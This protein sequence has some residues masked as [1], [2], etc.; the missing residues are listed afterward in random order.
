MDEN[1]KCKNCHQAFRVSSADL[2]FYDKISPTFAQT[3]CLIP[4]PTLC[5]PCRNMRRMA[6]RNDRSFHSRKCDLTGKKIVALYTDQVPFPVF[7]HNEWYS[8]KWDAMSYGRDIDFSRPFFDQWHDLMT[9]VPRLSLDVVNCENSDYCNYCGDDKNCYLDIAGEANEDCYYNLFTKF[10]KNCVDCTFVYHSTLCYESIHCYH[11]YNVRS[12]MYLDTCSDCCFCFDLKG[13]KNCL[14]SM[15]LRNKEYYIFNKPHT[16]TEYE[17]KLKELKL[18]SYQAYQEHASA[19]QAKRIESGI[20]RDMYTISCEECS[21]NDIKNSKNC[22]AAFNVT[23]C[24]DCKYLYDVLNAKD[25]YDL[26]YSLYHPEAS[27]ELIS[28]LQLHYSAFNMAT[29][30]CSNVF[31]C[32]LTNHSKYL[33][34]CIALRHKEYC[35]LNKQYSKEDYE[36]LVPKLIAHMTQ[37]QEWG[38]FFPVKLSPFGFNETVAQEYFPLSKPEALQRGYSWRDGEKKAYQQQ[39][40]LLPDNIADVKDDVVD[41][42][43]ACVHCSKNFKLIRQEVAWYRQQGV[44]LP[45]KCPDCRHLLRLQLRNPR[46]LWEKKCRGC[47]QAIHTSYSPERQ[48]QV[49]CEPCYIQRVYE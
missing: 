17:K 15:N 47:Q 20:Y 37:T 35:I 6:W 9:Q 43:L 28:T 13:C 49:F 36:M 38:E 3:K 34:G 1:K 5:P 30:Y 7:Q 23:E 10:S 16:K 22:T 12:S 14:F 24:W 4:P 41:A 27:C 21:G 2:S 26:N 19:W 18:G 46:A 32:D 25:C 45:R 29:H 39:A 44:S 48:E 42:V 40:Y 31:Y 11:C 33:F 8:D